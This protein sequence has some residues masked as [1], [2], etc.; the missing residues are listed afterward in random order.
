[1]KGSTLR[2][3]I[4]DI[5]SIS[6]MLCHNGKPCNKYTATVKIC[7]IGYQG[8]GIHS[9]YLILFGRTVNELEKKLEPY[10]TPEIIE[11]DTKNLVDKGG[12]PYGKTRN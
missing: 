2:G 3:R 1:M 6:H 10:R 9:W 8:A 4:R 7:Q 5:S 12:H 11:I